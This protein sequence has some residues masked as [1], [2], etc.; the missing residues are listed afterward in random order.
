MHYQEEFHSMYKGKPWVSSNFIRDFQTYKCCKYDQ[1]LLF[2]NSV[3]L[4]LFFFKGY[5]PWFILF[6]PYLIFKEIK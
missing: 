4:T 5:G 6:D 3:K 2:M 1:T